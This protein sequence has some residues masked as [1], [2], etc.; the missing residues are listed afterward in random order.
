MLPPPI[1]RK[2]PKKQRRSAR[3]ECPE[4]IRWVKSR[5]CVVPGCPNTNIDPHHVR[6]GTHTG[7][8]R[9][10][11]DGF[12]IS[13]CRQHHDEAHRGEDS[14]AARHGLDLLA[15]AAA[16]AEASPYWRRFLARRALS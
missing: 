11:D 13:V 10:P 2:R 1:R 14:F 5:H 12:A 8:G 7:G 15:L 6:K 9:R 3:L 4:H 16:F